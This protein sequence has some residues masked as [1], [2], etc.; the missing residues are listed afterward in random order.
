MGDNDWAQI[1]RANEKVREVQP[2]DGHYVAVCWDANEL[3][4][5]TDPL[6]LRRAYVADCGNFIVASTRLDWTASFLHSPEL[7]IESLATG[8]TFIN[9]F[10]DDSFVKGVIRIGPSGHATIKNGKIEHRWH[11]WEPQLRRE[12][13]P[14]SS[15]LTEA[16]FLPFKEGRK[17]TLGLSGGVDSRTLLALLLQTDRAA[18]QVHSLG[19]VGNPDIAVAKQ[20]A[21]VLGI[22]IRIRYDTLR[23][24]ETA[25]S[26]SESLREYSLQTEMSDSPFG[27]PRLSLFSEMSADGYWMID[28]G[29]G[30]LLRRSYGNRLLLSG[31]KAILSKDYKSLI[32]H[33]LLPR[34]PIFNTG[35]QSFLKQESEKQFE[36][37]LEELPPLTK[38]GDLGNWIDILHIR[39]RLKNFAGASQG[40]YDHYIPNYMPFALSTLI[41]SY[42]NLS[43]RARSNNRINRRIVSRSSREVRRAPLISYGVP[44]PYWTIRNLILSRS[45]GKFKRELGAGVN[46]QKRSF[47][48]EA[49]IKLNEFVHDRISSSAV[50]TFPHYAYDYLIDHIDNFYASPNESDAVILDDWLTFDFWREQISCTMTD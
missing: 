41:S 34:S 16:T 38:K 24:P 9:S 40:L 29:Y 36:A 42:L 50:R 2:V 49:L 28:G 27:Y 4:L 26:I 13:K 46:F 21:D 15:L 14:V 30:E 35:M 45:I 3:E 47:R 17:I 25:E 18:W 37:A 33:F 22:P 8:W 12:H 5:F 31:K 10:S 20:L 7:S 6:G 39:Y 32:P 19:N 44:V 23:E 43:S 1:L 48:I 11:H